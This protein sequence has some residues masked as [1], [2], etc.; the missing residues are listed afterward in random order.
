MVEEVKCPKC[1]YDGL[2]VRNGRKGYQKHAN[3][4]NPQNP[5]KLICGNCSEAFD[6]K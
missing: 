3:Q 6:R 2:G 5:Y 1:G 4:I